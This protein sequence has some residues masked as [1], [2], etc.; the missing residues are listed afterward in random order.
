MINDLFDKKKELQ[1]RL[2]EIMRKQRISISALSKL[3]GLSHPTVSSFLNTEKVVCFVTLC[4]I[5]DYVVKEESQR[6]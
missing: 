4:K 2:F 3:I 5:E 1:E 6:R